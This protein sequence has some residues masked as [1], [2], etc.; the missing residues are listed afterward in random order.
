MPRGDELRTGAR[1]R[2]NLLILERERRQIV[3][4]FCA[5]AHFELRDQDGV[6]AA[7]DRLALA[8]LAKDSVRRLERFESH[9]APSELRQLVGGVELQAGSNPIN[10][11]KVRKTFQP[12][13][14][15]PKD[16]QCARGIA[17]FIVD[18]A[19]REQRPRR[20]HSRQPCGRPGREK[21][22]PPIQESWRDLFRPASG[23]RAT[24][25]NLITWSAALDEDQGDADR[26]ARR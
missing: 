24:R 10:F 1:P 14:A 5:V 17:V 15:V 16:R 7:Q 21:L 2:D 12:F 25:G 4:G 18:V 9:L 3:F 23:R 13:E 22:G 20:D 19:E 26:I 6:A 11:V 8:E